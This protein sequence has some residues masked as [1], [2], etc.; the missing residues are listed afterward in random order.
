M[1]IRKT[2]FRIGE[3]VYGDIARGHVA[4]MLGD[5]QK[6]L[7]SALMNYDPKTG[8]S[9]PGFP[10]VHFVGS[11]DGFGLIGF[12]EL[13]CAIVEDASPI[14]HQKLAAA[15]K[16]IVGVDT[17]QLSASLALRPY[18]I[19]YQVPRM[20]VQSKY[21]YHRKKMAHPELG[22]QHV[23]RLFLASIKRQAEVLGI[24]VPE[25]VVVEFKGAR[26]DFTAKTSKHAQA[27]LGLIDAHFDINLRMT[28]IWAVGY[29]LSKGFGHIDANF[30]LGLAGGE[31]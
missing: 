14:I 29:M 3:Q 17:R 11:K 16:G 22:K 5:T 28:G 19:R 8:R 4:G 30:Q 12:G 6:S 27:K 20:V 26:R 7:I 25:G 10:A 15:G 18:A 13:G 24:D 23:E 31:D 21:D 2:L 9:L 1:H